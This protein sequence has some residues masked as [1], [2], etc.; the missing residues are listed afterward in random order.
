MAE[1]I[2]LEDIV[3]EVREAI[4]VGQTKRKAFRVVEIA[5]ATGLTPRKVRKALHALDAE[6][7]L[8]KADITFE[9]LSGQPITKTGFYVKPEDEAED[10]HNDTGT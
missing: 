4:E 9:N 1:S 3:R 5:D 6:G 2:T 8:G 7:R 10:D